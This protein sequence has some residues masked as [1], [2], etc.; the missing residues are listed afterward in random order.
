M[1]KI[2]PGE[3]FCS[4]GFLTAKLFIPEFM[5]YGAQAFSLLQKTLAFRIII[6]EAIP[7]SKR[8]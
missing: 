1:S 2:L 8:I 3:L 5:N 4:P 7:V 6:K